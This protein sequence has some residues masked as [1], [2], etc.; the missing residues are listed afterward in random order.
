MNSLLRSIVDH[1]DQASLSAALRRKRFSHFLGLI[2]T[3][4]RPVSI[5]DVGGE[6]R[7][8]EVM[9]LAG[10]PNYQVVLLNQAHF[11]TA[12]PNL[13]PVVGDAAD[14]SRFSDQ[15]FQAV[16]SNSVIEHLESYSRQQRMAQEVQRVGQRYFVQTPNRYFPLEPHFLIPFFQFFP[17]RVQ[18]AL[19]C[20]FNLG[21]Y[22]RIPDNEQA[23]RLVRSH[24]LLDRRE[25]CL[26]FPRGKLYPEIVLGMVKSWIVCGPG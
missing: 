6:P 2:A 4:P 19:L 15:Q 1:R 10:D 25:L 9:G 14:L 3:F 20:R 16:F 21:W 8:W 26:L 12:Q 13:H 7:F 18:I 24:R 23:A 22:V 5:L 11:Q 17:Q